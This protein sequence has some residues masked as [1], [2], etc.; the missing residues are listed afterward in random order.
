MP[1]EEITADE[2]DRLIANVTR[3]NFTGD[4]D[5][6]MELYCDTDVC[7]IR[8]TKTGIEVVRESV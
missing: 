2:Y 3:V 5:G 6:H 4:G 8:Y 7:E 1:Y